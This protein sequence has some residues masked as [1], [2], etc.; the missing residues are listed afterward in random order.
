MGGQLMMALMAAM[1]KVPCIFICGRSSHASLLGEDQPC[2]LIW[3]VIMIV[4]RQ[5]K[6]SHG[7]F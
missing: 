2:I 1:K 3:A 6:I 5:G 4:G 7:Y